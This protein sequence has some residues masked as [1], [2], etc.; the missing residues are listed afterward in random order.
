MTSTDVVRRLQRRRKEKKKESNK[1]KKN[2]TKKTE[3]K[4]GSKAATEI[5]V[6]VNFRA[7]AGLGFFYQKL[8]G[9]VEVNHW[10]RQS[11]TSCDI[12]VEETGQVDRPSI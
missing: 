11:G 4:E 7:A 6:A 12:H 10:L 5:N 9:F 3:R 1:E 2:K 8:Q